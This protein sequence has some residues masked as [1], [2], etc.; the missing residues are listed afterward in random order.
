M[1]SQEIERQIVGE[2]PRFAASMRGLLS[3]RTERWVCRGYDVIIVVA[4]LT[5]VLCLALSSGGP[6]LVAI[7]LAG[8]TFHLRPRRRPW[9]FGRRGGRLR[10][11][12]RKM[13]R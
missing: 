6:A 13:S 4:A 5:A 2:D 10:G 3:G 1:L 9:P 12:S 11:R 7:L 8:V